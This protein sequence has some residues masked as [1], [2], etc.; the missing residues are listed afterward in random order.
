MVVSA[1]RAASGRVEDWRGNSPGE[2]VQGELLFIQLTM[3]WAATR[4]N[5]AGV[6]SADLGINKIQFLRTTGDEKNAEVLQFQ[7]IYVELRIC[8]VCIVVFMG[9][10]GIKQAVEILTSCCIIVILLWDR[11]KDPYQFGLRKEILINCQGGL[12]K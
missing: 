9:M 8:P 11:G 4:G 5:R 1:R 10:F 12:G 6:C 3:D 2:P 7:N